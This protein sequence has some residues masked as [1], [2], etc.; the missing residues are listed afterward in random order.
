MVTR[1]NICLTPQQ[2]A[3]LHAEASR[4]E[5]GVS[6]VV[7]KLVVDARGVRVGNLRKRQSNTEQPSLANI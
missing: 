3:F 2:N 4:L 5:I 6:A 1:M 7:Q